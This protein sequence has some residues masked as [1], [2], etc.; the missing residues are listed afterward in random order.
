MIVGVSSVLKSDRP[1][2]KVVVLEPTSSPAITE[3]HGGTHS[4]EGIGIGRVPPHLVK[5]SYDEARAIPEEKAREMCRR[6]ARE[7]GILVGVSS[8]LNVVAA[9]E[10]AKELGPGK[11]IVTMG[12]DS[13]LK[14][15][16]GDLFVE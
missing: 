10:L 9:I 5:D 6:L 13:G 15:L 1:S 3:G 2:T 7:E 11:K 14:Y 4:V 8:G 16:D 12:C